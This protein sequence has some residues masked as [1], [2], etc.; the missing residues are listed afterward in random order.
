MQNLGGI[1][2]AKLDGIYELEI[3]D[4]SERFRCKCGLRKST[5]F[6][7]MLA[8]TIPQRIASLIG[9][10][11]TSNFALKMLTVKNTQ[12]LAKSLGL[13]LFM[14]PKIE[15]Y[16]KAFTIPNESEHKIAF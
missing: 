7:E 14:H 8:G 15:V 6:A 10:V 12:L 16:L 1:I 4:F 2:A 5:M 13:L 9:S 11:Q 3:S